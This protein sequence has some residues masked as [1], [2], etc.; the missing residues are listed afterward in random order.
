MLG[1]VA[2][3]ST[4]AVMVAGF[5][6]GCE[7]LP[8]DPSVVEPAGSGA[9]AFP[10]VGIGDDA[11]LNCGELWVTITPPSGGGGEP[12]SG[13]DDSVASTGHPCEG[14]SGPG[15]KEDLCY[16]CTD[17]SPGGG[18][19]AGELILWANDEIHTCNTVQ[20]T[21]CPVRVPTEAEKAQLRQYLNLIRTH[22]DPFCAD[23]KAL[24]ESLLDRPPIPANPPYF[25]GSEGGI[26]LWDNEIKFRDE[27]DGNRWKTLFGDIRNVY[28]SSSAVPTMY[29]EVHM[30][31]GRMSQWLLIHELLHVR[32]R[33]HHA[34]QNADGKSMAER[35]EKCLTD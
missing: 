32:G 18:G 5:I 3:R 30:W 28:D 21:D 7:R 31:T 15:P 17:D 25:Y 26:L 6:S 16:A 20:G 23:L 4:V 24:G 10:I 29:V 14:D 33:L 8:L 27:F 9:G 19:G 11:I 35:A 1:R 12:G 2:L 34:H 22:K 13:G